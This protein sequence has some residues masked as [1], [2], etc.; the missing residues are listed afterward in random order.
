MGAVRSPF[1]YLGQP[2]CSA[3]RNASELNIPCSRTY[4][5]KGCG[6]L[7]ISWFGSKLRNTSSSEGAVS[8]TKERDYMNRMMFN[9]SPD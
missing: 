3:P 8:T 9:E 7:T 6:L 1:V 2:A 5:D 4:V